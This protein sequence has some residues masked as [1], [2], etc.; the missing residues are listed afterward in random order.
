MR[1]VLCP[2]CGRQ[3][4]YVDSAEIYHGVSYG[5]IYLCRPCNA[6]VGVHK[7]TDK[8]KGSLADERLRAWRQA[9]HAAFDPLWKFGRF[10]GRRRAAYQWLA[11]KTGL[12]PSKTHIGMFDVE[13]CREAIE[14]C[15]AERSKIYEHP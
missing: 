11:Q 9:A 8:P 15:N 13:Q 14:I 10:Y 6:Y 1:K 7:G 5:M 12:P 3:A 2:Y 4:E